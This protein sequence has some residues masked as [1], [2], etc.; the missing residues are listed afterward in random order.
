MNP[1]PVPTWTGDVDMRGFV[2][3]GIDDEAEPQRTVDDDHESS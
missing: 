2:I 3:G 1:S